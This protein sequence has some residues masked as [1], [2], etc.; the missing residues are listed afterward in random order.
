MEKLQA[1]GIAAM[2]SFSAEELFNDPHLKERELTTEIEHPVLGKQVVLTPPWKLSETPARIA[3]PAPLLGEHND[4]VFG[5][6]LGL[7]KDEI[8]RLVE[9]K[10]IY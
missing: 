4:Y 10:V 5:E 7:S 2:P 6:L 1:A 9:D 3:K 8:N